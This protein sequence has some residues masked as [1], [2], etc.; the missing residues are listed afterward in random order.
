M[1]TTADDSHAIGQRYDDGFLERLNTVAGVLEGLYQENLP[2]DSKYLVPLLETYL[3]LQLGIVEIMS[4]NNSCQQSTSTIERN[5]CIS[6]FDLAVGE[7][8]TYLCGYPNAKEKNS[9]LSIIKRQ[10][11]ECDWKNKI[12]GTCDGFKAFC[13]DFNLTTSEF[14]LAK[15]YTKHY[16]SDYLS[17]A[18]HLKNIDDTKELLRV[19]AYLQTLSSVSDCIYDFFNSQSVIT[20]KTEN[21]IGERMLNC[22]IVM[23]NGEHS[24]GEKMIAADESCMDLLW[25]AVKIYDRAC[26]YADCG[27]IQAKSKEYFCKEIASL[28]K[29]STPVWHL[30]KVRLDINYAIK[31]YFASE[32]HIERQTATYRILLALYGGFA[33]LY[34]FSPREKQQSLLEDF[35]RII[36]NCYNNAFSAKE[37]MIKRELKTLG[38][39]IHQTFEEIRN[40]IIHSRSGNKRGDMILKK[41]YLMCTLN[42]QEVIEYANRFFEISHPLRELSDQILHQQYPQWKLLS[43]S[44]R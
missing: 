3:F 7:G 1:S 11:P 10:M 24:C 31:S 22:P 15:E 32:T 12:I 42:P 18:R 9:K 40:T 28:I 38:P 4:Y 33:K 41:Y 6:Y 5:T 17:A 43:D 30:Q 39:Q 19:N 37:R 26:L 23:D 2:D 34:G 8:I 20:I 14:K 25:N 16:W 36:S 44:C 21:Y 35:H 27:I 29:T 13:E